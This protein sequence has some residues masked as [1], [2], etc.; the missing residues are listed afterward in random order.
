MVTI[1]MYVMVAFLTVGTFILVSASLLA[2]AGVKKAEKVILPTLCSML[3]VA[4]VI[5][6]LKIISFFI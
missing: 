1:L 6:L 2:I 3:V 4:M 5:L